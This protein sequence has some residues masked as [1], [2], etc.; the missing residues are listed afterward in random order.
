MIPGSWLFLTNTRQQVTHYDS[1]N[2]EFADASVCRNELKGSYS[3]RPLPSLLNPPPFSSFSKS[4]ATFDACYHA[5]QAK[6]ERP[7]QQKG[8][9]TTRLNSALAVGFY[10]GKGT[11]R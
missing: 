4:P 5:T 11:V 3:R 7:R 10:L 1:A 8:N 6:R 2:Q 9:K